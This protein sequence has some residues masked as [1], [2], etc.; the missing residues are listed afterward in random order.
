MGLPPVF[1]L[2]CVPAVDVVIH[3]ALHLALRAGSWSGGAGAAQTVWPGPGFVM[4]SR[5]CAVPEAPQQLCR[6]IEEQH[7]LL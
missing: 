3:L 1:Q 2:L 5:A 4:H 6:A 7:L